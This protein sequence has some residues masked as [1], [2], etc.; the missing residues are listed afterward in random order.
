MK[1]STKSI[2]S[3]VSGDAVVTSARRDASAHDRRIRNGFRLT[4][5]I[6]A[7]LQALGALQTTCGNELVE[8]YLTDT[9]TGKSLTFK[10]SSLCIRP[11]SSGRRG[12]DLMRS[13]TQG[14]HVKNSTAITRSF[15]GATW[16]EYG[17]GRAAHRR[18][19]ERQCRSTLARGLDESESKDSFAFSQN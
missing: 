7:P 14:M 15:M 1:P 12:M 5:N 4:T 17:V 11:C 19:L 2:S 13:G 3:A 10:R 6:A 18:K 8:S 9:I 16:T